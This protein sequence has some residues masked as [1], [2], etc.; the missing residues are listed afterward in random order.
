MKLT[1]VLTAV[2]NNEKYYKFIPLFVKQWKHLFPGI[3]IIIVFIGLKIPA[4]LI[5]YKP[6]IRLFETFDGISDVFIA[7]TIRLLYPAV[8]N[9]NEV[10]MIT[11]IDMIP[12]NR[13]SYYIDKIKDVSEDSFVVFRPLS[14]VGPNE[15]AMCYNAAKTSVWSSV[16][17]I[18]NIEDIHMFLKTNYKHTD[19]KH[20]GT[21]WN[22]DQLIL[23]KYVSINKNTV[24]LDDSYYNRLN[25]HQHN[26]DI[27]MFIKMAKY[28][29]SDVH[30]YADECPWTIFDILTITRKFI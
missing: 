6:Y 18:K 23:Y 16:F 4:C 2:N 13:V 25:P 20:N 12:G 14:C 30:M 11:D 29:F 8:L 28:D 19:G 15:I 24:Y 3:N 22:Q 27:D 10:T 7:Q 17:G 5:P 9:L 1:T 21:G 26:Y